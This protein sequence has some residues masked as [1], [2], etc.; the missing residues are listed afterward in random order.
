MIPDSKGA[1][2]T[3]ARDGAASSASRRA[4]VAA[5]MGDTGP[6]MAMPTPF[7]CVGRAGDD[8]DNAPDNAQHQRM[9]IEGR[10]I[11]HLV[12]RQSGRNHAAAKVDGD[13]RLRRSS[14]DL[15]PD[16]GEPID[17][18]RVARDISLLPQR[19]DRNVDETPD[20]HRDH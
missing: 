7:T 19:C 4:S 11:E 5:I 13:D 9:R 15:G 6:G 14:F 2:A 1:G 10:K 16:L 3:D 20:K 8:V 12:K 18:K 17:C